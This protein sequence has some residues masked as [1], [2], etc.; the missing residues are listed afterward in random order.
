MTIYPAIDIIVPVYRNAS[1]TKRCIGSILENVQEIRQYAP[2]LIVINDSPDDREVNV[3]VGD[4]AASSPDI[5][6]LTN[7]A[8]CGFVK[9]VNRGLEISCRD[10]HDVILIN[11]DTESFKGTLANLVDAAY[12]DRQIRIRKPSIE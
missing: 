3:V 11:S 5:M 4:L 1:A 8:N 2:R 6:L 10:G 9:S 12:S 7:T